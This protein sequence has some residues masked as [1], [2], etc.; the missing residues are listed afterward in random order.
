MNAVTLQDLLQLIDVVYVK[1]T[2]SQSF[3]YVVP[4]IVCLIKYLDVTIVERSGRNYGL[5]I[6]TYS[7]RLYLRQH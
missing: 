1:R 4:M 6:D 2:I 7:L 3:Q 5:V